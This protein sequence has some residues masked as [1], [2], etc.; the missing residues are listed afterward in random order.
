MKLIYVIF[1]GKISP[2]D[3]ANVKFV[4]Y[5]LKAWQCKFLVCEQILMVFG[6]EIITKIS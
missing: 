3:L 5:A 4:G 1:L 2:T 6:I